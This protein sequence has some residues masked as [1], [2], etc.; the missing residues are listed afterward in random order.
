MLTGFAGILFYVFSIIMIGSAIMMIAARNPVHSV[1]FL[2]LVFF[3]ASALFLLSGAEFLAMI[4]LMV[5]VGAVAVL[6]L[7]VVMMLDIDFAELRRG[8][9]RYVPI[10]VLTALI[11]L[12]ELILIFVSSPFSKEGLAGTAVSPMPDMALRTNTQAIGDILYTDYVF[13]FELA[14][15]ILLAAMI[16]AIVLALHHRVGVKRQSVAE[17][18]ARNPQTAIEVKKVEFH[19]GI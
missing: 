4:L 3:N 9:K 1:L 12:A 16:G 19:K 7:F 17:Q 8:I 10:G 14:G 2:I 5:Y 18:V 11:L 15:F 6:F 13:Y